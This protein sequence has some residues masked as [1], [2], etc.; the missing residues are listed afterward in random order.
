MDHNPYLKRTPTS[1][2]AAKGSIEKV[3]SI[4]NLVWQTR[5]APPTDYEN[6]LADL[7]EQVFASG[8]EELAPLVARLNELGSKAPDGATWTEASFQT[9]MRGFA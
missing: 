2:E 8:L 5:S 9:Y 4:Q 3:D 7:L 1:G 6:R